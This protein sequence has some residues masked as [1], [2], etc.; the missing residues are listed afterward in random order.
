[1]ARS[2]VISGGSGQGRG[3]GSVAGMRD[4]APGRSCPPWC[5]ETHTGERP[6]ERV[7]YAWLRAVELSTY[8]T[9]AGQNSQR[10]WLD[11]ILAPGDEPPRVHLQ[12]DDLPIA[13]LAADEAQRFG[14]H[15]IALSTLSAM[16]TPPSTEP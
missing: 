13:A 11:L 14:I 16:E 8:A 9:L 4:R 7:H 12:L 2:R 5:V 1:M 15:L 10:L 6:G 3:G